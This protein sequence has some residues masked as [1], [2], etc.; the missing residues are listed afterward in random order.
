MNEPLPFTPQNRPWLDD[1]SINAMN[2][3]FMFCMSQIPDDYKQSVRA[4]I[5]SK[6]DLGYCPEEILDTIT[7][8][9]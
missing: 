5:T 1:D 3:Q 6:V 8:R 4:W 2:E 7:E 9:F